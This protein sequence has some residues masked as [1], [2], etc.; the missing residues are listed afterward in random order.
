[1]VAASRAWGCHIALRLGTSFAF[2]NQ[3][4]GSVLP[5]MRSNAAPLFVF[6]RVA[7]S[8]E[9]VPILADKTAEY[10]AVDRRRLL[11]ENGLS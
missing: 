5:G 4:V 3:R 6:A 2:H 8:S 10:K 11:T 7:K 1:M 9:V